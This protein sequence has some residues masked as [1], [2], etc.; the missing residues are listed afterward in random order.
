MPASPAL[1]LPLGGVLLVLG[2]GALVIAAAGW[3]GRLDRRGRWG[4]RTRA[5]SSSDSAFAVANRVAAPV[6]AAAG[7][8]GLVMSALILAQRL[9]VWPTLIVFLLGLTGLLVVHIA[10]SIAG[11]RAARTLPVPARA[12]ATDGSAG[13]GGCGCGGGG[14]AGL[15]RTSAD[16]TAEPA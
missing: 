10:G 4:V 5:A 7:L 11:E 6:G 13:C 14:C 3:Q 15:T 2:L 16:R 1:T 9:P 8:V 12:P